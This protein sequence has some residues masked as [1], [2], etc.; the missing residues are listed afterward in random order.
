MSLQAKKYSDSD[1]DLKHII[2]YKGSDDFRSY[3]IPI[4]NNSFENGDYYFENLHVIKDGNKYESFIVRYNPTDDSKVFNFKNFT[5]KMEFFDNKKKLKKT[6]P[7]E[8]GLMKFAPQQPPNDNEE[9]GGGGCTCDESLISKF[10]SWVGNVFGSININISISKGDPNNTG[11]VLVVTSPTTGTS[12]G[13]S[14]SNQTPRWWWSAVIIAPNEPKWPESASQFTMA[15]LIAQRLGLDTTDKAWLKKAVNQEITQG[16]YD[17]MNDA[18]TF[19]V[20]KFA[21]EIIFHMI[22]NPS[23]KLD[24]S[25]SYKS[26]FNIDKSAI[27]AVTPEGAKFNSIYDVLTNSPE[28]KKLFIDMFGS[29]NRF[30]VKFEIAEH[31]YEDND[32]TKKEVN[33][34]TSQDPVTKN[35]IIKIN[36]QILIANT[37]KSQT[38]IENAKTIL[39]ECIHAYLFVKAKNP[40]VGVDIVKTLNTMYPTVNEQHDFMYG[41]MI[42]T[43]QKVLGEIRDLVT[44]APKREI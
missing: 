37:P 23:L 35:I 40:A 42:P 13:T 43:M 20:R 1:L 12:G 38:K 44:T 16:I 5:G 34:T 26:P 36:K 15:D 29:N 3:S 10:F 11:Y 21:L 22:L 31:V 9:G 4:K 24:I 30:N 14:G 8:N 32:P 33:A 28:F 39:H 18:D 17:Y 7:F 6:V 25:A 41:K 2:E 19:E 27:N